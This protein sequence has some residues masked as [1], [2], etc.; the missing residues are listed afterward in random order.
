MF[1]SVCSFV[2]LRQMDWSRYALLTNIFFMWDFYQE[3]VEAGRQIAWRQIRAYIMYKCL[4]KF[5]LTINFN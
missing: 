5:I 2:D 3:S 1:V 4:F